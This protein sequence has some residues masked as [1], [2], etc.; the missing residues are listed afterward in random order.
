MIRN[1][2]KTAIRNLFKNKTFTIINVVGLA[3]GITC[4]IGIFMIVNFETGFDNFH[5]NSN[6]IYRVVSDFHYPE[7]DQ[8][9]PGIPFPLPASLKLDFPELK[10]IGSIFGGRNNQ[11]D[12]INTDTKASTKRFLLKS[13]VF[14]INPDFFKVFSF[15]WLAGDPTT[16][17]SK[18]NQ[19]A[20]TRDMAVQYFGSWQNAIGRTI[21]KDNSELL[22]VSGIIENPPK[23]SDFQFQVVISYVSMINGPYANIL[24]DWGT[25][26]SAEQCYIL[27]SGQGEA[28]AINRQLQKLRVKY[29]G[30]DDKNS[31]LSIQPLGDVHYNQL[32]GNYNYTISK[33]TLWSLTLISIF[34]LVLACIN[35][36]NLA[37]AQ[38]VKRSREVGIRKVL[39]SKRWQL[40]AQFMV[41]T[42]II[43]L[44]A[45]MV[46]L[47]ILFLLAPYAQKILDRPVSMNPLSSFDSIL[48]TLVIIGVVTFLSGFYLAVV[49]SGFKPLRAIKNKI[50]SVS[51]SGISL[52]RAL[53]VFQFVIAQSLIIATLVVLSQIRYFEQAPLGFNKDAIVTVDIPRDNVSRQKWEPFVQQLQ[54]LPGVS[55]VSLCNNS[56]ASAGAHTTSFKFNQ[57]TKNESFEINTK[58]ADVAYFNVY[59][60]KL[61]AGTLYQPADTATK[62]VVNETFVK[63]MGLTNDQAIGKFLVIDAQKL[64]ISGVVKDFHQT[65][66]R[67]TIEPLVI[68]PAKANYRM[69]SLKL[70]P[71]NISGTLKNINTLY[72]KTFPNDLYE[73]NFFDETISKF[74][75]QEQHLAQLFKLFAGIGIFI[76]CIG[77][78]GLV[79]FM[80]VQ[81]IKEVGLRK[82]LGATEL[83][84]VMLFFKEFVGLIAIAFAIAASVTWYL[85]NGWLSNF[86]YHT[87][88]SGWML[89]FVGGASILLAMITVSSQTIKAALANPV[90][91]LKTE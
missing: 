27:V 91:S 3:L 53:V 65:S 32:Y 44:L 29:F 13:G 72:N 21:K 68:M 84:I 49:V 5:K 35:F 74:Y 66:L 18:P 71:Q 81:R 33:S 77:L 56:P 50:T 51:S 11:L 17:L 88:I 70:Q 6:N 36:I 1:Y 39:G 38:A 20:L 67:A 90:K 10:N 28:A 8:H 64:F 69:V 22:Q 89:A 60:L 55:N 57:T 48:F 34:L 52:R 4:G 59:G 63:K 41:E 23:N 75:S 40:G 76:S 78:Y 82:V 79:L 24:K 62:I 45:T 12:I 25:T 19:V 47:G 7:G 42:F 46:A 16:V 2:L 14:Y 85:M 43:V 86:A 58:P 15:K 37:T 54:I 9:T 30:S 87:A 80:T 26:T 61:A 83:N 31:F 73:Y